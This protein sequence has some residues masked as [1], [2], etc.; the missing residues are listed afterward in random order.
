MFYDRHVL[1]VVKWGEMEIE[2]KVDPDDRRGYNWAGHSLEKERCHALTKCEAPGNV[3]RWPATL[4]TR[5]P[6]F[7][8]LKGG[9]AL[10][11][12]QRC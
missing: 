3:V 4:N 7:V 9:Q 6:S 2:E 1:G 11:G 10:P 5:R 8:V 12:L